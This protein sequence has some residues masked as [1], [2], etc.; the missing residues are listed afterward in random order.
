MRI[1]IHGLNYAPELIGIGRYTGELGAWLASRGHAVTVLA[2]PPYYPQW[3]VAAG[4]RPQ[5]WRRERLDGVEVLRAPLYAP[6]R[7]TGRGRLLHELS[8]GASCLYWW[9]AELWRRRWDAVVAVCP[10]LQS[11]LIPSLLASRQAIALVIHIQDLQLDAARQLG[12]L[13]QP[14][15]LAGLERLESFLWGR[16]QAVTTISRAMAD[17][18]QAKGVWPGRLHVLPNWTISGPASPTVSCGGSGG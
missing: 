1:L 5:R 18:I 16:A 12:L 14:A 9:L 13:R 6:S 17:R 10:P 7:V 3:R 8:F 4:Y 11:G 15:L 2:A